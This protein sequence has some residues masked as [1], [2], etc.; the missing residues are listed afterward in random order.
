[1][2]DAGVE[3]NEVA[4]SHP[5]SLGETGC[6]NLL[7]KCHPNL[8]E[9]CTGMNSVEGFACCQRHVQNHVTRK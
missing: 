7:M 4:F 2:P 8:I 6:K 9:T 3:E 1:M 5:T